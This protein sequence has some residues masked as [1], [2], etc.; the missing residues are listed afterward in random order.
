MLR[1][2][3]WILIRYHCEGNV[4]VLS[5]D[6]KIILKRRDE[7]HEPEFDVNRARPLSE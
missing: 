3:G 5:T 6:K 4:K 1:I 2:T 7:V